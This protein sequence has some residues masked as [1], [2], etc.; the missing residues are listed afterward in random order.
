[1]E[2]LALRFYHRPQTSAPSKHWRLC[3]TCPM[4]VPQI[5]TGVKKWSIQLRLRDQTAASSRKS[6]N[7]SKPMV[8]DYVWN[9]TGAQR[10]RLPLSGS[11]T[12]SCII[13]L[14][15]YMWWKEPEFQHVPLYTHS[16]LNMRVRPSSSELF[17][18]NLSSHDCVLIP[19]K[20]NWRLAH[21]HVGLQIGTFRELPTNSRS[22]VSD[23]KIQKEI[24]FK[25]CK[26]FGGVKLETF[27]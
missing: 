23:A 5:I 3:Q 18:K 8:T 7:C 13:S 4:F 6:W 26:V 15:E 19:K 21:M 12:I 25:R 2:V 14:R 11:T 22:S 16:A 9:V 1:M 24:K 10:F 17:T 20:A 27:V